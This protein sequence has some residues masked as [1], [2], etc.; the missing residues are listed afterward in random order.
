MTNGHRQKA[1]E[2]EVKCLSANFYN[3]FYWSHH[4]YYKNNTD[5]NTEFSNAT[6]AGQP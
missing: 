3:A 4:F 5:K 2:T 1:K 6:T